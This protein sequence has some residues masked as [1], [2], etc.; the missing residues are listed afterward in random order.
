VI[1][2]FDVRNYFKKGPIKLY[3]VVADIP[4]TEWPDEYVIVGGHIDSWD[5][6]TGAMD[7]GTGVAA[8]ME[9][10]RLLSQSNA[11][12][13][14]TIR[15]MLWSGEE[16]GLLGSRAYI[17]Q[18]TQLMKKVSAVLVDDG[19]TNYVSG[20]MTTPA[21]Q[22]DLQQAL[23]PVM[24]L[25]P[26]MPFKLQPVSGLPTMIGSDQDSFVAA[27]VPGFYFDQNGRANYDRVHHTQHDTF[28]GAIAEYQRHSAIV[29]ALAA[30]GIA[31]LDRMLSRENLRART[32]FDF[33][34]N[35]RFIGVE[36]DD[37]TIVQ[38]HDSMVGAKAGL[39]DGDTFVKLDGKKLE[40][41]EQLTSELQKGAPKKTVT[42]VRD[43]KEMDF[44]LDWSAPK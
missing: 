42:I 27:G 16:Q 6:A 41:R 34:G 5:G 31:N 29:I 39:R 30:Y 3:N 20:M 35:R 18:N 13:R 33:A 9:A 12:P 2:E 26:N 15:F 23:A 28:E 40:S 8:V 36:L 10:A 38:V 19:G 43:G 14:R 1:L 37:L 21:M 24:E 7:N 11:R 22:S 44:V 4:G 25:D 17:R 32:T